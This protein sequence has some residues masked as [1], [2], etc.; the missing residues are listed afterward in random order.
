[1]DRSSIGLS[2]QCPKKWG[3]MTPANGGRFC[4]DCNKIVTDYSNFSLYQLN[5]LLRTGSPSCGHFRAYQ[6]D[7]PFGN[8]RDKIITAYQAAALK[9]PINKFSKQITLVL[10]TIILVLTGCA[11]RT[12]GMIAVY[13]D[14]H[15]CPKK[16]KH[17]T[18][19]AALPPIEKK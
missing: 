7:R 1:M 2:F 19:Q 10:L 11:R 16:H 18:T 6:L 13:A 12:K 8:W 4:S 17:K 14:D 15:R 3:A 9:I 5:T